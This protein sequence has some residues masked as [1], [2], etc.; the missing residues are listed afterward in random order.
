MDLSIVIPVY[1]SEDILPN[2]VKEIENYVNFIDN[3]ELILVNDCSPDDSWRVIKELKEKYKFIKGVNLRKNAGQHNAIMAGLNNS[4]GEVIIMMDDD[5]QH[6]PSYIKNLY[7]EIKNGVDVCYTKFKNKKHK[8]WKIAGSKFNDLIANV[9]LK[10]PKDLYLSSFKSISKDIKD[11][12][13]KYDGAYPYID[14][15]IILTTNNI[16]TIEVKHFDRF[17]GEGN[18]NLI[19]STSL[20]LKMATNFS[21]LPLRFATLMGSIISFISFILGTYFIILKLLFDS[22]PEG[23]T[24]IMVVILFL[25]GIQLI[26]LGVIG[27]YL[28]RSYLKL[29]KKQQF[30]IKEVI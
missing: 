25:G 24:S 16:S 17:A 13:I 10:K 3:F 9:L 5:L 23:W 27:E 12:I 30:I 18:Y 29:N 14:G 6:S 19:K 7:N 8:T 11:E 2:L 26:S 4:N 22:S 15:L 20:W 1:N 28:G 21:I